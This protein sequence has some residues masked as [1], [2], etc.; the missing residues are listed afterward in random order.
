[1]TTATKLKTVGLIEV[2]SSYKDICLSVEYYE[3]LLSET[4]IEWQIYRSMMFSSNCMG[5]DKVAEN[6]DRI[7]EKHNNLEKLLDL[8][9]RLKEQA[10][11]VIA[12]F[13]GIDY[14]VAYKR[15]VEGKTLE[16]IA[17]EL[18]YSVQGVKKISSRITHAIRRK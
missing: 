18:E 17:E 7:I 2:L 14:K 4:Q 6:L 15:F 5:M 11:K 16:K 8:N 9:T 1:M 13:E 3:V 10:E 12:S